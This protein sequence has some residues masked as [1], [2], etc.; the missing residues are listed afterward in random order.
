MAEKVT[1]LPGSIKYSDG[2]L[3]MQSVYVVIRRNPNRFRFFLDWAAAKASMN[4]GDELWSRHM[5]ESQD[6]SIHNW[7]NFV[8]EQLR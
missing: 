7:S 6:G 8:Q 3:A 2:W 1:R 4:P 5:Y